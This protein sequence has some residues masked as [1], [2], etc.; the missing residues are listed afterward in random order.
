[1]ALKE[2][3]LESH[4]APYLQ[5]DEVELIGGTARNT[6]ES[7]PAI[8]PKLSLRTILSQG[9]LGR[10]EADTAAGGVATRV[11]SF[12][13]VR[14]SNSNEAVSNQSSAISSGITGAENTGSMENVAQS[15]QQQ[16]HSS[17]GMQPGNHRAHQSGNKGTGSKEVESSFQVK[18]D[19]RLRDRMRTVGFG[20]V[21]ALNP[22][23]GESF[24]FCEKQLG[25]NDAM[26]S[27]KDLSSLWRLYFP[28]F[29]SPGCDKTTSLC[30]VAVLDRSTNDFT[31]G[32]E[33]CHC[34]ATRTAICQM[35]AANWKTIEISK[36]VR[37]D[38]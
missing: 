5:K 32:S 31:I 12:L 9:N 20:L 14:M 26:N 10:N 24:S 13:N 27:K 21:M 25:L 28:S 35:A 38:S 29:R 15:A 22:G 3:Y 11:G 8:A 1:M 17:A 16:Q 19:W 2:Y 34:G 30:C 4:R 37:P 33:R 18:P 36:G 23:T 6:A 7:V